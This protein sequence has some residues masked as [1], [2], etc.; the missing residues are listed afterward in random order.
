[1]YQY[2]CK[3][4]GEKFENSNK[5]R[6]YCS[7]ECKNIALKKRLSLRQ[8]DL[9][10]K[11]FGRLTAL[12]S[13]NINKRYEWLCK[14]K[15]GKKVWVKTANLVN[16]HTKSCGCLNREVASQ[17]NSKY[18]KKYR[19]KNYV[20]DTSISKIK[21]KINKNNI[22]GVRGVYYDKS[23]K[24]WIG[25]LTYKRKTYSKA[26][27]KKSDAI[28]YRKHL[29]KKYFKPILDKYETKNKRGE[30]IKYNGETHT[31]HEWSEILG[32]DDETLRIRYKKHSSDLDYVFSKKLHSNKN[33]QIELTYNNET[34]SLSKWSE[35]L[36]IKYN[37][38]YQRYN[39]NPS[40]LEYIF[41]PINNK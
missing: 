37:T 33:K 28:K 13:R 38:L 17:N 25:K 9:K 32:I 36:G 14:C 29:E 27:K 18:F 20:E 8:K 3:E 5:N 41:K 10:N 21:A 6:V 1:M 40:N 31:L 39:R 34:H 19:Q 15:C 26:F 7:N 12:Y 22:S 4:C 2:I 30:K 11:E 35:I 23:T 24:K 16:G